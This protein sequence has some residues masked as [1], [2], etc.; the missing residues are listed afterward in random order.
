MKLNDIF[1]NVVNNV[2][3]SKPIFSVNN[4]KL[5]YCV[6]NDV[7]CINYETIII[8]DLNVA[9]IYYYVA[10]NNNILKLLCYTCY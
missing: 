10:N 3:F 5:Y 8:N 1:V 4:N 6:T 2:H 7:D 9:Q